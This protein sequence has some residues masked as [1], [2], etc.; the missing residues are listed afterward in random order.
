MVMSA[1]SFGVAF[2]LALLAACSTVPVNAP[3]DSRVAVPQTPP[4]STAILAPAQRPGYYLVRRGDTLYSVAWQNGL[5]FRQLADM[6]AI[7]SPYTIYVGQSLRIVP[8][9]GVPPTPLPAPAAGPV[10]APPPRPVAAA[11]SE[12][13][14]IVSPRPMPRPGPV[15]ATV[16]APAQA[17]VPEPVVEP[18]RALPAV[19]S[20]WVWPTRGPLLRSY[21]PEANG[22]KGIDIGGKAGQPI[23]SA[24]AGRV[25]YS[26]S[27]LVGYGRL[28]II[29]HN[30]SLLSAYGHNS[31]LLVSEGDYV[32]AGQV[33][34]KMGSSGTSSTRLYFEIRQDGKPVNP[35]RYLPRG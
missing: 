16:P 8:A 22:K 21:T 19:V 32:K 28:I 23:L 34:A 35:L 18:E 11:R 17:S 4:P 27:G 2:L 9:T 5:N 6:N 7:R 26:G 15:M 1:R 10:G 14:S 31:E 30:D 13:G 20:R 3:V 24:A 33:I 25:V 12:Q 29:K